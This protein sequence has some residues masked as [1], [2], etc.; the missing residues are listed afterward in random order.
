M[1]KRIILSGLAGAVAMFVWSF[2]AH[3]ILPLGETGVREIANEPPVLAAMES[4]LGSRSG[5]Y[6]FPGTGLPENAT[7]EQRNAAMQVYQQKIANGPS[8]ILIYHPPGAVFSFPRLL[9]V[10]FATELILAMLAVF[11]LTQT[12]LET[13]WPRAGFVTAIG[14]IAAIATNVSYWNWYGFPAN[15]TAAYMATQILGFLCAGLAAAKVARVA[16]VAVAT[17]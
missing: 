6:M 8:G 12:R 16:A 14:V 2:V 7:S 1:P 13:Y 5:L 9:A 11:L 3:M 15:Y 4:S 17:P 10:E